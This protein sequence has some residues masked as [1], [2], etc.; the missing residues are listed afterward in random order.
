MAAALFV[1]RARERRQRLRVSSAGIAAFVGQPPPGPVITLMQ[2]R[3][4]DLS[5]HKAQQL[6]GALAHQHDLILVM[7]R[8]QQAF[9]EHHWPDLR[10]KVHRLGA[11]QDQDVADP[12][13]LTDQC[14][15]DCLKRIEALVAD[16]EARLWDGTPHLPANPPQ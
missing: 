8:S 2:G 13:G 9:V 10:G 3:G 4:S 7:D 12:Y 5:R 14:Y 11:W 1:Q 16:W 15:A 6:T